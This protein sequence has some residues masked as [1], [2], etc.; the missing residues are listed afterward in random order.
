[1]PIKLNNTGNYINST[2]SAR[3]DNQTH[4]RIDHKIADNNNLFG[5]VSWSDIFQRDP[6]NLPN[7]FQANLQQVPRRHLSDT[8]VFNPA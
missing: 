3:E 7:A 1:M 4:A 6:Q 8:H 5:R 2:S